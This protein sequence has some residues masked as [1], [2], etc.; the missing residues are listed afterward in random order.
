MRKK[1]HQKPSQG[2]DE[3]DPGGIELNFSK[4][5]S[6]NHSFIKDNNKLSTAQNLNDNN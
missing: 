5:V 6:N 4:A 3:N 1:V 2:S